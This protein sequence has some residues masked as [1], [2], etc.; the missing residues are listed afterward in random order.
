MNKENFVSRRVSV[1]FVGDEALDLEVL[2]V[3][4]R[5]NRH[6]KSKGDKDSLLVKTAIAALQERVGAFCRETGT[7]YPDCENFVRWLN[8]KQNEVPEQQTS[9]SDHLAELPPVDSTD[10]DT[11]DI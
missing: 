4:L 2:E 11:T 8:L 1:D 9:I 10:V 7:K 5:I 3:Q 6:A